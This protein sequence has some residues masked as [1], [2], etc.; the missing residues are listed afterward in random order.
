[1]TTPPTTKPSHPPPNPPDSRPL[2]RDVH[3]TTFDW[4]TWHLIEEEDVGQSP[5]QMVCIKLLTSVT[6]QWVAEQGWDHLWV[7]SDIFTGWKED[8]PQVMVSPDVLILRPAPDLLKHKSIQTWR[9]EQDPPLWAV[10]VVSDSN[11][12]KDYDLNPA[13]YHQIGV[14]ELVMFDPQAAWR[15]IREKVRP[16][17]RFPRTF[18]RM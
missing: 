13:K 14:E 8:D 5:E 16:G 1:M 15:A 9:P 3:D 2:P 10:E 12:S 6:Q 18:S 4:T 17:N 11:K 7:G